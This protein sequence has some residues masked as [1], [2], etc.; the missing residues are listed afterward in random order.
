[1][2]IICDSRDDAVYI[3]LCDEVDEMIS[4]NFLPTTM[5]HIGINIGSNYKVKFVQRKHLSTKSPS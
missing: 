1:M 5:C 2:Y 3:G 4:P